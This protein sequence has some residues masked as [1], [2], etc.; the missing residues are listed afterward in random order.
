MAV[1]SVDLEKCCGTTSLFQAGLDM[2]RLKCLEGIHAHPHDGGRKLL[3][4]RGAVIQRGERAV[5]EAAALGGRPVRLR[6]DAGARNQAQDNDQPA[7]DGDVNSSHDLAKTEHER[8]DPFAF[9]RLP[10]H[11]APLE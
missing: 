6:C 9:D 3:L 2:A 1:P 7:E 10:P 11:A 8:G 5:E 4:E